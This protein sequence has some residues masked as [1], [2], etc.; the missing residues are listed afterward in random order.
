M[1]KLENNITLTPSERRELVRVL[2]DQI[3]FYSTNPSKKLVRLVA[4]DC[5]A[6]YAVLEDTIENL[7][8]GNGYESLAYQI[9]TRLENVRRKPLAD[10]VLND[11]VNEAKE[12]KKENTL[13]WTAMA[14]S[15]GT[16]HSQ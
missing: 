6:K 12:K 1:Q 14:V 2:A 15:N 4:Q 7:K 16:H 8:I 5:I 10:S 3:L 9:Y 11:S 13:S